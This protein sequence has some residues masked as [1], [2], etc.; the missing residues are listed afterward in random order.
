MRFRA[1]PAAAAARS[2]ADD[3]DVTVDLH[4]CALNIVTARDKRKLKLRQ[5]KDFRKKNKTIE[6]RRPSPSASFRMV[7]GKPDAIKVA[8]LPLRAR[9]PGDFSC[10]ALEF[11]KIAAMQRLLEGVHRFRHDEFGKYKAM[12]KR[13]SR[14]GQKPHTL[15][16]T[17]ADSR[18]LAE[19]ITQSNPGD[20]FVIKNVGNIVPAANLASAYNSTGAGIEFA[21]EVLGVSDVVV[22]GHS[23]CGAIALRPT[24]SPFAASS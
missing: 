24:T 10:L 17:C 9:A 19:L 20:L 18:V 2:V 14:Q 3:M 6:R 7:P 12:F 23:G 11:T 16:I 5:R 13:L 22:C 15:F 21:I 8:H 1:N 4:G